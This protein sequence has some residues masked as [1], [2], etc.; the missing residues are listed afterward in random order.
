MTEQKLK[1][2]EGTLTQAFDHDRY[3]QFLRELLD[4]MRIVAP[5]R[6]VKPWNTFSAAID[7]Y[8]HIGN[9]VGEDKKK[10]ALFSVC[11]K[12]DKN[13]E[14]ARSMQ[15]AF[16]KTLLESGDCAG[17]LVAFYTSGDL[18]KW[19]L[20]LV[21][22]DYEFSKGKLSEK[23][24]PAKRYSYLVGKGEPCHTAQERL[25]PIFVEDDL[26]PSLDELEEAF[27]VEAVTKDFFDKYREKYLDLK[28][29]LDKNEEFTAE[30]SSRSFNSEQF[31][32]KLMG[33][34]VFLYFIQKKGWLGVNAFPYKL[35][36]REY[37]A[38]FYRP[39]RKPKELMPLVF[40]LAQDGFYYRDNKALLSLP[41]D[42]EETL[43]TLVKGDAWGDGPKDFMRLIFEGCKK[44]GKNFFDDYLE[45]LFYTGLNQNRG[46]NAFFQ[47]LHR[48]VPFLNGGLFEEMEGYDWRNNDFRIPNELFSNADIKGKRDADGILDVFDRYNFTMAEDEPMEREV[49][50]DPEMLGKV[51]ENLLDVTNRK[52]KGAFYTPREI[53]H[54]MCQETLINYLASKTGI[55][56]DDIR[57]FILYG[58]YFRDEDAKK[59]I[60]I[61]NETGQVLY[62]DD[63]YSHKHHMEF[64]KTKDLEMPPTIFS[65]K[66]NVNRLQ[67]ID[68]LLANVK[69]VDLAVGSGA[70][71]LGMLTEI[72]KARETVTTYMIID[73]NGYQRLSYRSMR[74]S[75]R[76]KRETVKNSIFACDIEAS[77]TDITKLRLWLS[78]VIDNQ[79]M[80]QENDEFGYTTKPR[81]LPNLDCNIICGNSLVDEFGGV[82]LLTENASLRNES[83]GRQMTTFD[84]RVGV[85]IN[86]LID[87]Q[88]KL[89]DEKDH[90][91][92]NAI[93]GQ[94]ND[95]YNQIIMEQIQG[96]RVLVDKYFQAVQK[97]SKPFV[98]WQLYFPKVFRDNGGFDIAIGNPPYLKEIDY[99]DVFEP[100]TQTAFGRKYAESKM[101]FW[102]FFFH[103]GMD[104][105]CKNGC[106]SFIAPNYF[107]AGSGATKL[108]N[109][110]INECSIKQY[111]D[112]NKTKVF[113]TADVQCMILVAEKHHDSI[114]KPF[115]AY[116]FKHKVERDRLS[117]IMAH[118]DSVETDVVQY[119]VHNQKSI[120]SDDFKINFEN[121]KYASLLDLIELKASKKQLFKSTQGI[122]ENPSFLN[123]KNI[124]SVEKAGYDVS[125]YYPGQSVFVIP[126]EK[127]N[128]L[129]LS[130]NELK[131]LREYHEPNEVNRYYCNNTFKNYLLYLTKETMPSIEEFPNIREH[132]IKFKPFM[133]QRRETQKGSIQWFQLHWPRKE[134]LFMGEKIVY[135]QMGAV[136]TFAYSNSPFFTNMSA[137]I[138]YAVEKID[139]KVLTCI[140]NS[141][142]THFWLLHRAKNRGVGLDIAVSVIDKF[143]VDEITLQDERLR[144]LAEIVIQRAIDQQDYA[145]L[146]EEINERVY[147]LYG[148]TKSMA[149]TIHE[150]IEGRVK[151]G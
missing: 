65:Y 140:L 30:A 62:G 108:N 82:N 59:T 85:L 77:A 49:A 56:S 67:E 45:P 93:K 24:T 6:E 41:K 46:D 18:D 72:V 26:D 105:L 21:R 12:N 55:A 34:I 57:K 106:L 23:L 50:I 2:F 90:I 35:S 124:A 66:N 94:I 78:L 97:P 131:Y 80:D 8:R 3:V 113:E 109:R 96:D 60:P 123:K 136:P 107:V 4:N 42:D 75:Y 130:D 129:H 48:R 111:V 15:R 100:V 144:H 17:A 137:N 84:E 69:V 151:N 25:Y 127:I 92:K 118:I 117:Y 87:L 44:A 133:D 91:S 20:S 61:D 47:P 134:E 43:S 63:I 126:K 1:I 115:L 52:S 5:N 103:K 110:L 74:N 32:K 119:T 51:F 104:L 79:I 7:H 53:V 27:S 141:E 149:S 29:F 64:D 128:K 122:V 9:Y 95:I 68:D 98:L 37:K 19:R 10:V 36:E 139:L 54:Y 76:M 11:L 99:K 73:M 71:P 70:F 101:N 120:M 86:E 14:N 88:S 83:L 16:V 121:A 13:L 145:E 142:M 147:E 22:M 138:V 132:L 40:K 116:M 112:F 114:P 143:P 146:D 81:E 39:G 38:G 150:Y 148:I 102:Y 33:Q 31:A 28:E 125:D 58:E 89:Y 135:P